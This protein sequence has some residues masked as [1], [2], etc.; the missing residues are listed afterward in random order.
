MTAW[1][2]FLQLYPRHYVK[3]V[4]LTL[5]TEVEKSRRR[6]ESRGVQILPH[7]DVGIKRG[8]QV[9]PDNPP[10]RDPIKRRPTR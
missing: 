3:N 9:A 2:V 8:D 10:R 5:L 1:M 6:A 4:H 7:G